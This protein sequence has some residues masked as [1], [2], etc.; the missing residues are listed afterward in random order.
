MKK[1]FIFIGITITVITSGQDFKTQFQNLKNKKKPDSE[2]IMKANTNSDTVWIYK[3][4]E[5]YNWE[6][7]EYVP[8]LYE[9]MEYNHDVFHDKP[10]KLTSVDPATGDSIAHSYYF[11]DSIGNKIEYFYQEYDFSNNQW[12]NIEKILFYYNNS[13]IDTCRIKLVWN[14]DSNIWINK[15]RYFEDYD[16]NGYKTLYVK[17][18]WENDKWNRFYGRKYRFDDKE[19]MDTAFWYEWVPDIVGHWQK[20]LIK[21]WYYNDYGII[22]EYLYKKW[23]ESEQSWINYQKFTDIEHINWTGCHNYNYSFSEDED[24]EFTTFTFYHWM[25]DYW[26]PIKRTVNA[27][28]DSLGGFHYETQEWNDN[29]WKDIFIVDRVVNKDGFIIFNKV[30]VNQDFQGIWKIIFADTVVLTYDGPRLTE[31]EVMWLDTTGG[32]NKWRPFQKYKYKDYFY[33]LKTDEIF[34]GNKYKEFQIIPN[35]TKNS[36][37]IKLN[38]ESERIKSVRVYNITGQRVLEKSF[39][40]KRIQENLNVSSLKNGTFI[41]NVKTRNGRNIK[42]K[43]IKN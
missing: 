2:L 12:K 42:G 27:T 7:E 38:D 26:E 43:F 11:Y 28:A 25:G 32:V 36:I 6:G 17:E 15:N 30:Q 31:Y 34:K 20:Y 9:V 40:G 10:T 3:I 1:I 23:Y 33:V 14:E 22:N 21:I 13:S 39:H 29:Q 4:M 8:F 5:Y 41:I 18:E 19:C 35:P 37:L 16:T 24:P